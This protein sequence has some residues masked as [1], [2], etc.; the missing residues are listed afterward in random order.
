MSLTSGSKIQT[1]FLI[2]MIGV[3]SAGKSTII[4]VLLNENLLETNDNITT[5]FINIIKYNPSLTYPSFTHI[6]PK[7]NNENNVYDFIVD[8]NYKKID[9]QNLKIDEILNEEEMKSKIK[10]M[11]LIKI[12]EEIKK[13]N[14]NIRDKES[15]NEINIQQD[16]FYLTEVNDIPFTENKNFF[17]NH[18]LVD[19]PGL[20]ESHS[21]DKNNNNI[22]N[23]DNAEN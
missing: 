16:L 3:I 13:I 21:I 19:I 20:S 12:K 17:L 9:G 5:K 8:N 14:K 4:N 18:C 11:T 22:I 2:P 15:K 6:I 23:T 1:G 10:E 7:K